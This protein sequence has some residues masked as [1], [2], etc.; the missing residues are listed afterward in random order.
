LTKSWVTVRKKEKEKRKVKKEKKEKK[1][2]LVSD[3]FPCVV[4]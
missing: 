1:F 2:G 3:W 4:N